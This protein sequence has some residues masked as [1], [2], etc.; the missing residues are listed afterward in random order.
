MGTWWHNTRKVFSRL[1]SS[2]ASI[3]VGI[4]DGPLAGP[5]GGCLRSATSDGCVECWGGMCPQSVLSI[6]AIETAPSLQAHI[7]RMSH[8]Y[9]CCGCCSAVGR[10]A[11]RSQRHLR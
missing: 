3:H 6:E 1:R 10:P 5:T 7:R 11:A 4:L 9:C 2:F 8:V